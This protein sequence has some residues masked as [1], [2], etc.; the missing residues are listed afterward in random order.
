[1]LITQITF[2]THMTVISTVRYFSNR[3]AEK[4]NHMESHSRYS[5][6][7]LYSQDTDVEFYKDDNRTP[8]SR[9]HKNCSLR[10]KKV[11][12]SWPEATT[13]SCTQ[14][15]PCL[16]SIVLSTSACNPSSRPWHDETVTGFAVLTREVSVTI[17]K[18]KWADSSIEIGFLQRLVLS[19]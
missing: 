7:T 4:L 15:V 11:T 10:P 5:W 14:E 3:C 13:C 2:A 12:L 6:C 9:V 16:F 8:L 19:S 1:V 17:P 18:R